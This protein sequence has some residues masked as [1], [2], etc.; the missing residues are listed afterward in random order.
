LNFRDRSR[1]G[2][3]RITLASTHDTL[4]GINEAVIS[5]G[6]VLVV[7]SEP[8]Q[9]LNEARIWRSGERSLLIR[10]SKKHQ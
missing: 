2:L 7:Y 8:S 10:R 3:R 9:T 5:L 6:A 4:E 1:P